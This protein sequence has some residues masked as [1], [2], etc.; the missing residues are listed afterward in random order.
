VFSSKLCEQ[1]AVQRNEEQHLLLPPLLPPL[2]LA[3]GKP[4]PHK[5]Q[6]IGAGFV[7]GVLN[8]QLVDEVVQV[9]GA[10]RAC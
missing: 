3:G 2:L 10:R 9:G 1:Y 6:G 8:T 4:G 7:P 5:I